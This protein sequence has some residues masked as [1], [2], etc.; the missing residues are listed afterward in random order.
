GHDA[1]S[2]VRRAPPPPPARHTPPTPQQ[3]PPPPIYMAAYTQTTM[4]RA[5]R[6]ADGWHPTGIPLANVGEMFEAIKSMAQAAGRDP[7]ALELI[8]RGNI[9]LSDRPPTGDRLDFTG[10]STQIAADI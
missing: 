3:T 1:G 4:A 5:A 9:E 10:T 8:V 2:A 7:A 6:L